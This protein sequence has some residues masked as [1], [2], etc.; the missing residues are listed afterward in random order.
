MNNWYYIH[1]SQVHQAFI[2]HFPFVRFVIVYCRNYPWNLAKMCSTEPTTSK[3]C[4]KSM[5]PDLSDRWCSLGNLVRWGW[6]LMPV[7]GKS[8]QPPT[9]FRVL[10]LVQT[11]QS[12]WHPIGRA[13]WLFIKSN[14]SQTLLT[15]LPVRVLPVCNLMPVAIS[16][17]YLTNSRWR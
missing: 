12:H 16:N 5:M 10:L 13:P 3:I 9:L 1:F 14:S 2:Y 8:V 17:Q 11:R 4:P 7:A 15:L 6:S